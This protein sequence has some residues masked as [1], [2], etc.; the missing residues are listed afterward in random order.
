MD[1][2]VVRLKCYDKLQC[3]KNVGRVGVLECLNKNDFFIG[4]SCMA[5]GQK[6]LF[7]KRNF[8]KECLLGVYRGILC[9]LKEFKQAFKSKPKYETFTKKYKIQTTLSRKQ[10]CVE[11]QKLAF[12]L[13]K[14]QNVVVMPKYPLAANQEF[15]FEY[16]PM[17]F[18]NEPGPDAF[19]WN[20]YT[21][22]IQRNQVNVLAFTNYKEN[23]ID[24]VSCN[25]IKANEELVVYYGNEYNRSQYKVNLEGC[26]Q[27]QNK[28]FFD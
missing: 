23:T 4:N 19:S 7:A 16:N 24:Y 8:P 2:L 9:P 17:I 3:E 22:N 20:D 15:Y 28:V 21:A 26:K 13:D 25:P 11:M 5:P 1:A 27:Y 6:G 14:I 12:H 18:V 10:T